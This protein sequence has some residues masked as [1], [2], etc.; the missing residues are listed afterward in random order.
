MMENGSFIT[1]G[2]ALGITQGT[3]GPVS[4]I[5]EMFNKMNTEIDKA[6]NVNTK[7]ITQMVENMNK[8]LQKLPSIASKAMS[9]MVNAI[10]IG[11]V[12]V[13][14][15]MSYLSG[16]IPNQFSSLPSELTSIGQNAML[17]FANGINSSGDI[18]ISNANRIANDVASTMRNALDIHSPS[19]V[20]A[21]IGHF[22]GE[23][24]AVGIEKSTRMVNDASNALASASAIKTSG[25]YKFSAG[26]NRSTE[27]ATRQMTQPTT[28][29]FHIGNQ[30]FKAF[31]D[32]ITELQGKETDLYMQF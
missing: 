16:S 8:E 29:N 30:N 7:S 10:N 3:S 12:N 21:K 1:Q 25:E 6:K 19:R 22:V 23:G 28:L 18:A 24:L 20:M 31:I 26:V 4:A 2:L 5:T 14:T 27:T 13:M 9:G 32:D 15:K 11:S 17:G